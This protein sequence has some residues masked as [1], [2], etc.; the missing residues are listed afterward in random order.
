MVNDLLDMAKIQDEGLSLN[1]RPVDLHSLSEMVVKLSLPL[2]GGSPW[3]SSTASCRI[4][5]AV[6]ADEDRIRQVLCNL[7]GNAVKFT[8]KGT[9]RTVRARHSPGR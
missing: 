2:A 1:L 9:D 4:F 8:N 5:P 6:H 3:K 7:V